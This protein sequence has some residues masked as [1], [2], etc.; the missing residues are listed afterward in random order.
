[1]KD[2][3]KAAGEV[4]K[5]MSL[6][7]DGFRQLKPIF[8]AHEGMKERPTILHLQLATAQEN[9]HIVL[10]FPYLSG[11]HISTIVYRPPHP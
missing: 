10:T 3:G 1:M 7:Q 6:L 11:T 2:V 4:C 8:V 5:H 9:E